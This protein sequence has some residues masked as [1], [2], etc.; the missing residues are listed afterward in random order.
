MPYFNSNIHDAEVRVG[1]YADLLN[2]IMKQQEK[3]IKDT[4]D[5]D[6]IIKPPGK[7]A[8]IDLRALC[9]YRTLIYLM[10]KR[11]FVVFYKQ[12]I[13]GPIWHI[14]QPLF[15]TGVFTLV[16]GKIA[17][18]PTD[19]LPPFL[20]YM[21]GTT[22]WGY[23]AECLRATSGTF[24]NNTQ[25]FGKVYFP[26]LTVPIAAVITSLIQLMVQFLFIAC[27]YGYFFV[28]GAEISLNSALFFMPFLLLYTGLSALGFGL[29]IA[30]VTA[31]YKDLSF[32]MGFIIQLWMYL[33]PVVYPLS[34][35]PDRYQFLYLLNPMCV[36]VE[37]FRFMLFGTGAIEI[38]QV[39]AGVFS[40][41][42]FLVIGLIVFSKTERTFIDTI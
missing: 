6:C 23:F 12:T 35:V 37:S 24:S 27:V 20:F 26:R 19:G 16:F 28:Q 29:I 9:E 40:M 8:I 21:A 17:K 13:L 15:N 11:D 5:W 2:L 14:L 38:Q 22:I 41:V 1:I 3:L 4:E 42:G 39:L 7:W 36:A 30:G 32:A 18:I 33:S 31:K 25:I 10:V 34:E